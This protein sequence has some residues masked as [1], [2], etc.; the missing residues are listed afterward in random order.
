MVEDLQVAFGID[1][2]SDGL[3]D[4]TEFHHDL[5]GFNVANMRQVRISVTAKTSTPDPNRAGSG[6]PGS[7]NHAGTD[8]DGY[9]RRQYTSI[10]VPRTI[11]GL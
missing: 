5:D 4:S 6:M 10:V 1:S 7:E 8:A 11:T 9:I 3:I 2:D